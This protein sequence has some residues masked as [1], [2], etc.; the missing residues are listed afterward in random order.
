MKRHQVIIATKNE[1]KVSE[2]RELMSHL[3]IELA[4]VSEIRPD[5]PSPEETGSTFEENAALKAQ[6]FATCTGR[7]CVADDSGLEVDELDGAPGVFSSRYAGKDGDDEA[8]N[9]EL[10]RALE[11]IPS[12]RRTARFRCV[13]C[14]ASPD[15]VHLTTKGSVE[16]R[17]LEAPRGD[18]GFGYDPLFLYPEWEQTLAEV[19]RAKKADV[20]HRG[21]ALARLVADLPGLLAIVE[22]RRNF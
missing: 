14:L 2:M 11:G 8:N 13:I 21:Q 9:L 19:S 18:G 22:N 7:I 3:D 1:H 10:L 15:G 12:E 16:G 6:Y 5:L 4:S 17:I 20:S